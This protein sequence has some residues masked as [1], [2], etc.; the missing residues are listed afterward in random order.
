MLISPRWSASRAGA[1]HVM[2]EQIGLPLDVL[3]EMFCEQPALDVG[4]PVSREVDQDSDPLAFVIGL[5]GMDISPRGGKY[6]AGSQHNGLHADGAHG[7]P[8]LSLP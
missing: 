6:H 1:V 4:R 8:P 3:G 5:L 7:S 2:H